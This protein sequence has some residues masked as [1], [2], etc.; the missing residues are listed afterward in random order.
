MISS[1]RWYLTRDRKRAVPEGSPDAASLLVGAGC[2]IID[3]TA[4][5]YGIL[6]EQIAAAEAAKQA[7]KMGPALPP[8]TPASTPTAQSAVGARPRK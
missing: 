2:P 8:E 4:R 5:K 7:E 6:P 1:R 3:A